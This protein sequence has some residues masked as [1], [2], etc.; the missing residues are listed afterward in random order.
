MR[1]GARFYG[2]RIG[3]MYTEAFRQSIYLPVKF[4]DIETFLHN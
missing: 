1:A 4:T 3:V 2:S